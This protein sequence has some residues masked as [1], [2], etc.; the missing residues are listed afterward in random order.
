[1]TRNEQIGDPVREVEI[2]PLRVP[3]PREVPPAPVEPETVPDREP[4]PA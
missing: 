1:M 4:V 3:T 2:Q